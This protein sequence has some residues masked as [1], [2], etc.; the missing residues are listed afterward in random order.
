MGIDYRIE[1]GYGIAIS[2]KEVPAVLKPFEDNPYEDG[3]IPKWLHENGFK[4]LRYTY[5]G[6][7]MCGECYYFF[8]ARSAFIS[9]DPFELPTL[10]DFT[11]GVEDAEV[12]ELINLVNVLNLSTDSIGW[13]LIM[14]VS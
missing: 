5:S 4:N 11:V 6:D 3:D 8:T 12:D 13:K 14:N 1:I 10:T 7:Y 9:S 2:E